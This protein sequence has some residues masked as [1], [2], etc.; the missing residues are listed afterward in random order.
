ML[1]NH[2]VDLSNVNYIK[3]TQS[4]QGWISSQVGE[5]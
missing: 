2:L 5:S 3:D 4:N 1:W